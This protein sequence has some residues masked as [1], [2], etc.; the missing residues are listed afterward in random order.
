MSVPHSRP[1]EKALPATWVARLLDL[2]SLPRLWRHRLRCRHE[3]SMLTP[4]QMRDAGIDPIEVR[5]EASK[6]FWEA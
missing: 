1:L 4:A 2:M 3:L 5:R 6:Y